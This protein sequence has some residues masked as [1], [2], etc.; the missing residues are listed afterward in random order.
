MSTSTSP[1]M[2]V[3][4][5]ELVQKQLDAYNAYD[6]DGL[7]AIYAE[8]ARLFEHAATLLASGAIELRERFSPRFKEPNLHAQLSKRMAG[9][10][11][12]SSQ[13]PF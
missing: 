5:E 10:K 13:T 1:N 3:T 8:R 4:P 9:P 2:P 7:L 11:T 6:I 12:L